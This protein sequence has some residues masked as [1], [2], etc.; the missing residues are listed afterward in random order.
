MRA[1]WL[2]TRRA[3]AVCPKSR[4]AMRSGRWLVG[5]AKSGEKTHKLK[6]SRTKT[7]DM[8]TDVNPRGIFFRHLFLQ[9]YGE[10]CCGKAGKLRPL[11]P[12]GSRRGAT[13]SHAAGRALP[14]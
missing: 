6:V 11:L 13:H 1:S 2:A 9:L 5:S 14:R 4:T 3:A 7:R 12:R 10:K 8:F